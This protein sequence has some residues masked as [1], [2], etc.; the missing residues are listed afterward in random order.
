[1]PLHDV[2]NHVTR[3]IRYGNNHGRFYFCLNDETSKK[4]IWFICAWDNL[5]WSARWVALDQNEESYLE[6]LHC[7]LYSWPGH[8]SHKG[9]IYLIMRVSGL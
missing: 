6:I 8:I 4:E 9:L 7:T 1:M 5:D 2:Q 3:S